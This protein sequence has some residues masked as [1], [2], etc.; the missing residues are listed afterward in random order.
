MI[1]SGW[2]VG[3]DNN[4]HFTPIMACYS[5]LARSK[6]RS[7]KDQKQKSE[8]FGPKDFS[9]ACCESFSFFYCT[10]ISHHIQW[11]MMIFC[12]SNSFY[13][14]GDKYADPKFKDLFLFSS[15]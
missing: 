8:F 12:T 15:D 5:V 7:S 13:S 10:V 2:T 1:I 6:N 4:F 9:S 3:A 11:T 14:F